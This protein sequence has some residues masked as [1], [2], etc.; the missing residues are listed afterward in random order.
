MK[1]KKK[2]YFNISN[3]I[4]KKFSLFEFVVSSEHADLLVINA[5]DLVL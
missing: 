5:A 2:S 4:L 1:L 3:A